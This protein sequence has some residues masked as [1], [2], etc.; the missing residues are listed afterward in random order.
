MWIDEFRFMCLYNFFI[1]QLYLL[2]LYLLQV[3]QVYLKWLDI[4]EIMFIYQ[5]VGFECVLLCVK[6][7]LS[8]LII[9]RVENMVVWNELRGFY[10]ELGK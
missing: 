4:N 3:I 6:E 8:W 5:L 2:Y 10:I 1:F 7:I 9:V